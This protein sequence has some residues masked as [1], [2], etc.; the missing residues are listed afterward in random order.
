MSL[1]QTVRKGAKAGYVLGRDL[2]RIK[3]AVSMTPKHNRHGLGYQPNNQGRNEQI[4]RQKENRMADSRL[5]IP[6]IHQTFR[7][8]G[9]INSSPF[10]EDK[11]IVAPFLTFMINA[12]T[13]KRSG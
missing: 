5:I 6:P 3:R 7:S 2:Q 10:G 12:T 9:Y 13:K 1:K 4:G 8:G 11:D